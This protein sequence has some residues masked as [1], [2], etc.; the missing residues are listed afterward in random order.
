MSAFKSYDIRGIYPTQ[1][2][3][4]LAYRVG[5]FLSDLFDADRI[6]VGRDVR[7]SS[8]SLFQALTDGIRDRGVEV[9]DAG[10]CTTPMVYYGCFTHDFPTAVMITASH[11]P[12]EYNGFKIS[13]PKAVP[14]GAES[15]LSLLQE[16]AEKGR[17]EKAAQR[18]GMQVFALKQEYIDFMKSK[19]SDIS[20]LKLS[21]DCSGGSAALIAKEILGDEH[22]YLLDCFDGSFSAH[23]PNPTEEKSREL[24][25]RD[26]TEKGSD[27]GILFD[28]D[29][30]RAVFIDNKGR[31]LSPDLLTALLAHR[32]VEEQGEKVVVDIRSSRIVSQYIKSIGG[33]PEI[34]KVGHVYAKKKLREL[35]AVLG[36]ELAGHYYFRDFGFCDSAMLAAVQLLNQLAEWKEDNIYLSDVVDELSVY[37]FSGE[38]NFHVEDKDGAIQ[39]VREHFEKQ[40]NYL[41]FY[42]FD[43]IRFDFDDWWFNIR[44]SNTEPYLRLVA[45]ADTPELLAQKIFFL[46]E[47]MG[48]GE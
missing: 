32:L 43:G 34:W 4:E 10:I 3:E 15:G 30:D 11:N 41:H 17:I 19:L 6:L 46:K 38:L 37:A 48:I 16:K 7:L 36:G 29:A 22:S 13:G 1:V 24:V 21:V 23:S 44:K 27:I 18:G 35:N 9:Y 12:K 45:E 42:D 40:G 39:R 47:K 8:D 5:Y 25:C 2:N 31:F 20:N 28:G 26:V 14:V 33:S